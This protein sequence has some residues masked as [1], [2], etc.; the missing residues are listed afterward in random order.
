YQNANETDIYFFDIALDG[1][2]RVWTT[3]LNAGLRLIKPE[4]QLI[5]KA[6]EVVPGLDTIAHHIVAVQ[7]DEHGNVWFLCQNAMYFLNVTTSRIDQVNL[8]ESL[9]IKPR[10]LA[11]LIGKKN[12]VWVASNHGLY[13]YDILNDTI[14]HVSYKNI[15]SN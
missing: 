3:S 12:D 5:I 11:I 15:L 7:T 14:Y 2:Q 8:P 1:Y 6:T 4:G 13:H 9:A 10:S